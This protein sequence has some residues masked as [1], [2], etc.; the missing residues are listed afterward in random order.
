MKNTKKNKRMNKK[1]A[2][3]AAI[4]AVAVIVAL[5]CGIVIVTMANAYNADTS[6]VF[7]LDGGKVVT[8]DIE[9]F[10]ETKYDVAELE[11]FLQESIDTYNS[12]NGEDSVVQK[13]FEVEEGVATLIMEYA[14]ADVYE[15]FYGVE[16]FTGTVAEALKAG[17]AF[18]L[19]FAGITDGKA[20]ACDAKEITEQEELKVAIIKTNT[21]VQVKGEILYL[22]SENVSE[23]GENWV[24]LKDDCNILQEAVEE[25][26]ETG[27]EKVEPTTEEMIELENGLIEETEEDTEIIFDFGDEEEA[28]EATYTEKYIYIIYK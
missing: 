14:S 8:T 15:D 18:D 11:K 4:A 23:F 9:N 20:A 7:V 2:I 3:I 6:T 24:V 16:L 21:R 12:E 22:S 27:T 28:P 1:V 19:D 5:V 17:Y 26:T 10:D 13:K 25:V